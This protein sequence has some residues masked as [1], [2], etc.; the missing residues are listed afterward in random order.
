MS[1]AH[2]RVRVEGDHLK[3]IASARPSQAVAELIWNAADADATRIDIEIETDDIAMRS[4]TVRDNGHGIP[5][6]EVE[7][8]FGKLGGSWKAHGN[9][10]KIKGRILHG[11]EGKGR[12]KALALGRVADWTVRY[13]EGEKLLGYKITVL[14]DDLVDVRVTKPKEVDLALGTGVEVRVT[15]LDRNYRSLDPQYAAQALSEIF[16]LYLTDYTDVGIY[17]E[18]ERLD[19]SKLIAGRKVIHLAP[20]VDESKEYPA[21]VEVIEW[22]SAAERW[23]FLCGPEGFP[24]HRVTPKFHTPGFQFSAYLKSPYVSALQE[25]GILDL[26]EMSAPLQAAY[27]EA[28]ARIKEYFRTKEIAAAQSEIEQWKAEE[29]YPYRTEPATTVE[30]AERQVFD[31]VALNV[32]K[33]LQDFAGQSKRTKAFQLRMLRQAIERGPD[34]LQHILTEVLDLPERTQ[35]ELSKLLEEADLANV[36]SASKL[37]ADRLKFVHGLEAVLFESDSKKLL[38]ERSQLHRIIAENNTWI[39]GEE[40]SLTVDDQ[41]LSEVLRKHRSLIGDATIIDQPVKLIDGRVG[42]VDLMLSRSVPQNHADEREHLVVEL[43]RPSVK[44]GAE[45]ITQ[46]QKYAFTVA[47]DE[48][49]R[50]LNTRWSFWVLSNDLDAYATHQ[51]R[52]MGKAKGLV[53]QSDDGRIEVWVKTWAE[54][55]AACKSRLRFVQEHLQ[56]NVD[57]ESSLKY[58]KRTYAKYLAGISE[59]PEG[60]RTASE[61]EEGVAQ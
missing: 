23:I 10:S 8:V 24:F 54:V 34:E 27:D 31:I 26:A 42:I 36:I 3:K 50:H 18:G 40:F 21:E 61:V 20:I 55:I 56:A 13:R 37:V 7:A 16:A 52:Q 14:R 11:K 29:I 33:H 47:N 49:F 60:E 2:Y 5:F 17:V 41:S 43:K 45:E 58:L 38:K 12:F 39:F 19:P 46:I 25:Q 4:V 22:T 32:N 48:R 59:T 35:K 57:R 51:T 6:S 30:K 53:Y 28:S 44:I 1:D 15:E 9:R